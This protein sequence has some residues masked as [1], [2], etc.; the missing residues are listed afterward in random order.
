MRLCISLAC[1]ATS[2]A[3]DNPLPKLDTNWNP[4]RPETRC[5][6]TKRGS[7][8][9]APDGDALG[10]TP[11]LKVRAHRIGALGS[12]LA[13]DAWGYLMGEVRRRG[14]RVMNGSFA[15]LLRRSC[16]RVRGAFHHNYRSQSARMQ[17]GRPISSL[18][19]RRASTEID[20]GVGRKP[21]GSGTRLP[22]KSAQAPGGPTVVIRETLCRPC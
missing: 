14:D 12:A 20:N 18:V 5:G 13:L 1:G 15:D 7:P 10:E 16:E 8:T 6:P 17:S 19:R 2:G 4:A 21:P 11:R 3:W 22:I 9:G